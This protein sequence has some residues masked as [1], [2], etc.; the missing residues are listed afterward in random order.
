MPITFS[1]G[2][3]YTYR[4]QY[5]T[6]PYRPRLSRVMTAKLLFPVHYIPGNCDRETEDGGEGRR[7]ETLP[8]AGGLLLRAKRR[9]PLTSTS[10]KT[11]P[12][13]T[14]RPYWERQGS[15]RRTVGHTQRRRTCDENSAGPHG[16]DNTARD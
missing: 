4:Q 14:I 15:G 9:I 3:E 12:S 16:Y 8:K 2:F 6:S 11:T 13:P 7:K 10:P 1:S 5:N